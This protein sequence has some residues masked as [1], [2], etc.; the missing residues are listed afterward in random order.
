[1]SISIHLHVLKNGMAAYEYI[2][3][4]C[5]MA[6]YEYDLFIGMD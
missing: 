2:Y 5:G 1:M 3:M 4:F 6:A